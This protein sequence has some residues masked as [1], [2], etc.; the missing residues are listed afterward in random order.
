MQGASSCKLA[1]IRA[2]FILGEVEQADAL[3]KGVGGSSVLMFDSMKRMQQAGDERLKMEQ[4][5]KTEKK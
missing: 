4:A 1:L 2:H 3:L 5:K